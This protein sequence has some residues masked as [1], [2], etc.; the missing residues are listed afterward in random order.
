MLRITCFQDLVHHLA[1][2]EE[3]NIVQIESVFILVWKCREV[4]ATYGLIEKQLFQ[5]LK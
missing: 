5:S 3:H 1:F 4:S 2:S